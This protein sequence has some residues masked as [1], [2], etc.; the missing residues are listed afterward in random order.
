[1]PPVRE[2][3]IV[4]PVVDENQHD[5]VPL[6]PF[7]NDCVEQPPERGLLLHIQI[8]DLVEILQRPR[9]RCRANHFTV[10]TILEED[11]LELSGPSCDASRTLVGS[12]LQR[13]ERDGSL[14]GEFDV[15]R[16][17]PSQRL[18]P[19]RIASRSDSDASGTQISPFDPSATA[20]SAAR[21]RI[22][23]LRLGR[24]V[25]CPQAASCLRSSFRLIGPSARRSAH[26]MISTVLRVG[27][28]PGRANSSLGDERE[29]GIG[30]IRLGGL[31][32][33]VYSR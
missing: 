14:G 20:P 3:A 4:L 28:A 18:G 26:R 27:L 33:R 11:S 29:T 17:G 16:S 6:G 7:M 23:A 32:I 2:P 22:A 15:P 30:T 25:E 9:Y 21:N 1:M 10:Q 24:D 31:H 13:A 8:R 12:G 19:L 5:D